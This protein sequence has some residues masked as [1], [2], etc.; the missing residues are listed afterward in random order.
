MTP[1][2]FIR[3]L[4]PASLLVALLA[5]G[6]TAG[7]S[8][9]GGRVGLYTHRDQPY[10]GLEAVVPIGGGFAVN[11]NAEYV[12]LGDTQEF[13]FNAD[14]QYEVPFRRRFLGW[15]GAGLGLL[16][17]HPDGPGEPSTKDGVA[18]LFLGIGL[19]TGIG[20]PYLTAKYVTKKDPQ[21]L[22]ALGM[23]F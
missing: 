19:D 3:L 9:F 2:V 1:R 22:I 17:S 4:G 15:A 21:F 18:N 8:L 7:D 16:S 23:R 20:M 12:R 14:L 6:A 11:P 10:F 13:T 5:T